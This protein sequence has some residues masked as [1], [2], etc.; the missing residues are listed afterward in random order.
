MD[1]MAPSTFSALALAM[2]PLRRSGTANHVI[3]L[4]TTLLVLEQHRGHETH[5][6]EELEADGLV[7]KHGIESGLVSGA[8]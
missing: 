1:A 4:E 8:A 6:Q 7:Q 3:V 5:D 2:S